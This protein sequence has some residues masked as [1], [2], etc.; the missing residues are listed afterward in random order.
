VRVLPL[1]L[2]PDELWSAEVLRTPT[3]AVQCYKK[4]LAL[5]GLL[6]EARKGTDKKSIHGGCSQ[7]ETLEHFTFRFSAS[8]GRVEFAV[9]APDSALTIVSDAL[10]S[11]L[12]DGYVTFL[13]IP[14]GTGASA[15]TLLSTLGVLRATAVLPKLPLTVTVVGGDCSRKALDVYGSMMQQLKPLV[16]GVGIDVNWE[17]LEWDATRGDSTANLIDQWFAESSGAGEYVVCLAN[18]S[19]ALADAG[20]FVEFSPSLEQIL[21]RLHDKKA[22][23]TWIEPRSSKIK[24]KF[25]PKIIEFFKERISWFFSPSGSSRFISATYQ[26]EDPL[27]GRVFESGVEVQRFL[28]K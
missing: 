25:L 9:L 14:C 28:R 12:A 5:E 18:F 8:V 2:I 19:G 13:D 3:L 21:G 15:V 4:V 16:A 7:A 24:K 23:L 1:E 20:A 22:T 6:D 10:L 11:S 27:N 26:I 17:L